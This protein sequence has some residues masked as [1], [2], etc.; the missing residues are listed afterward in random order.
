MIG[1]EELNLVFDMENP[2]TLEYFEICNKDTD[3]PKYFEKHHILPRCMFKEYIRS[4]WN[5]VKLTYENH[6]RVHEILP[7][8]C[9]N[10]RHVKQMLLAWNLMS[11][12][13]NMVDIDSGTFSDLKKM[14]CDMSKGIH[15][16][17]YGI[18]ASEETKRKISLRTSGENSYW[19]GREISDSHREHLSE[20]KQGAKNPNFEK[21]TSD[22]IKQ[23]ISKSLSGE[24]H[25]NFGRK[26]S[27]EFRKK[28]SEAHKGQGL[29]IP[30][31]EEMKKKLSLS[32]TKPP[33]EFYKFLKDN[34]NL[35]IIS[36]FVNLST[37]ALFKCD[38][39]HDEF[40]ALPEQIKSGRMCKHCK[41]DLSL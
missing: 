18:H 29:G 34:T 35:T 5:S 12:I 7:K 38:N 19:Y 26:A 9:I 37:Y 1:Y 20:S 22:E 36:E 23:K 3:E 2:L 21:P 8:I 13:S 27:E 16:P 25:Y 40:R 11:R 17:S 4:N 39:G 30:K 15:S 6:Y 41:R 32:L 31:S 33:E 10:L 14:F 28:L 24:N